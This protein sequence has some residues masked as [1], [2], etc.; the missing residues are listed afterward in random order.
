MSTKFAQGVFK[1]QSNKNLGSLEEGLA[2]LANCG[3]GI[4]CTCYGYLTLP[5]W[6]SAT[7]AIDGYYAV[8]IVDGA[9]KVDTIANAQ[10]EIDAIKA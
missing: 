4:E 3:C 10:A 6:N 8:Y 2:N 7:N 1:D 9:M 5:N